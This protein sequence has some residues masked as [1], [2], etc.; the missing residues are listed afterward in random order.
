VLLKIAEIGQIFGLLCSTVNVTYQFWTK[1]GLG[2]VQGDFF[3]MQ[4]VALVVV[5]N[6]E[7]VELVP[8][9][10]QDAYNSF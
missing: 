10:K 4:L 5:V 7:V 3:T 1:L 8:A 9:V 6:S 2:Y